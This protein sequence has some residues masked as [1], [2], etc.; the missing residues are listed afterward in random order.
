MSNK[1]GYSNAAARF[2]CVCVNANS[3]SHQC[4]AGVVR[5]RE[6]YGRLMGPRFECDVEA[7]GRER[8][9][10]AS[11]GAGVNSSEDSAGGGTSAV[12]FTSQVPGISAM[13]KSQVAVKTIPWPT[14][15]QNG[16]FPMRIASLIPLSK[17]FIAPQLHAT[18]PPM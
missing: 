15:D 9:P 13:G 8:A 14:Q 18:N 4:G 17:D 10:V 6:Y 11:P 1:S 16:S 7:S 5:N 12:S 2:V 3:V